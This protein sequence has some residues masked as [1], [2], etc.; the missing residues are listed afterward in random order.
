MNALIKTLF[1]FEWYLALNAYSL[2]LLMFRFSCKMFAKFRR[3]FLC[4]L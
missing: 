2:S 4:A 3:A 1:I